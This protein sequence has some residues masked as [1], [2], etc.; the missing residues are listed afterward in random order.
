MYD[1]TEAKIMKNWK[2]SIQVPLVS[3]CIITYNHEVFIAETLESFLTQ[4]TTFPFEIIIDEDFSTDKTADIIREYAK[5]YPKIIKANLRQKNVGPMINFI[6]NVQRATGK[7]IAVC[8]GDD[9]WINKHKLQIQIDILNKYRNIDMCFHKAIKTTNL[10]QKDMIIGG[11]LDT[12]GIVSIEDI[13][14]KTKGQIPSAS[15]VCRKNVLDNF[16]IYHTLKPGYN[17]G[18]IFIHFFGAKRGGSYFIN[19]TMSVYRYSSEGSWSA[20]EKK[21]D[22][23]QKIIN[24]AS[25]I[26]AYETLDTFENHHFTKA[27]NAANKKSALVIIKDSNIPWYDRIS[28]IWKQRKYFML[29]EKI[30]YIGLA[31]IPIDSYISKDT[32]EYLKKLFK[33]PSSKS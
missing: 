11:Y 18:D 5:K 6:K 29:N 1:I 28:F 23:T 3:I 15:L 20:L 24:T 26:K 30:V 31:L 10:K 21:R 7:Y 2:N 27:F 19:Q 4:E 14:L 12:N 13:L 9:Y 16:V 33:M 8:E 17:V 25:R 32:Y 22:Y